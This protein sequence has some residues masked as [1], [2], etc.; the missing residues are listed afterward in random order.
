MAQENDLR[1]Y[2]PPAFPPLSPFLR[3]AQKIHSAL[4]EGFGL[5]EDALGPQ[6]LLDNIISI[7]QSGVEV[8]F[9]IEEELLDLANDLIEEIEEVG[10]EVAQIP[11]RLTYQIRQR[12]W[13]D[14][15]AK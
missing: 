5:L 14:G 12:P 4:G 10:G 3:D 7:L 1:D 2:R 8:A 13:V 6:Q 9:D 15:R 11:P